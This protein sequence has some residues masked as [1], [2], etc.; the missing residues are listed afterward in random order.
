[1]QKWRKDG[2]STGADAMRMRR[3]LARKEMWKKAE[4][5]INF[6]GGDKDALLSHAYAKTYAK[7]GRTAH[8]LRVFPF[9]LRD[10]KHLLE[11]AGSVQL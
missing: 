6:A 4:N 7:T 8:S 9:A 10:A 1:M 2:Y 3:R 5:A 11:R